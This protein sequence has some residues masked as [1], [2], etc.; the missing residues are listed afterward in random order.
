MK[1]LI[2]KKPNGLFKLIA[3]RQE[4]VTMT[5]NDSRK[6]DRKSRHVYNCRLCS[7]C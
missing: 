7:I 6:S 3:L 5:I 2:A 1:M 4:H